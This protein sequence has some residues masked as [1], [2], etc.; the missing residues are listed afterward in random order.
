MKP[1]KKNI[2]STG[3]SSNKKGS[4][5]NFFKKASKNSVDQPNLGNEGDVNVSFISN[6]APTKYEVEKS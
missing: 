3:K 2:K 1:T 4:V 5:T 6:E